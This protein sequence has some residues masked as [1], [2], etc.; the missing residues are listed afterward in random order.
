MTAVAVNVTTMTVAGRV[1]VVSRLQRDGGSHREA[2]DEGQKG[3]EL[4]HMH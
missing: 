4:F 3:E 1:V 2:G